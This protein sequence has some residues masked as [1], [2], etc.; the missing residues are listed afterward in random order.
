MATK[1]SVLSPEEMKMSRLVMSDDHKKKL[2]RSHAFLVQ[3]LVIDEEFLSNF[4]RGNVLDRNHRETIGVERTKSDRNNSF[5]S[6]LPKRTELG[7]DRFI[8]A[9]LKTGQNTIVEQIDPNHPY[10][11]KFCE[12]IV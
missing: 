1:E 11:I 7:Y 12:N 6:I 8:D 5:L 10:Y 2:V 4:S 9:L 3:H